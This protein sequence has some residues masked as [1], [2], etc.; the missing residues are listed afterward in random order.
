VAVAYRY[1][2]MGTKRWR[3]FL[4]R[5]YC[6]RLGDMTTRWSDPGEGGTVEGAFLFELGKIKF[7]REFEGLFRQ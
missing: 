1:K 7:F 2:T 5:C 4:R 6:A 3:Y